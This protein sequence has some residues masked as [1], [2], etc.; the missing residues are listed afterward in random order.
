MNYTKKLIAC[1]GAVASD[2]CKEKR[3]SSTACVSLQLGGEQVLSTGSFNENESRTAL[4]RTNYS[5]FSTVVCIFG[6]FATV[7]RNSS[8]LAD[9]CRNISLRTNDIFTWMLEFGLPIK[10]HESVRQLSAVLM[11]AAKPLF[12]RVR[13]PCTSCCVSA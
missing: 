7:W 2:T 9:D 3:R 4:V 8:A 6:S 13:F 5:Y 10:D 11:R 12:L 1:Y